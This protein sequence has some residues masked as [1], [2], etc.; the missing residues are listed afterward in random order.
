MKDKCSKLQQGLI[1]TKAKI[2]TL[3]TETDVKE[4]N[5]NRMSIFN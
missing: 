3:N 5:S 2:N 1:H 4:D